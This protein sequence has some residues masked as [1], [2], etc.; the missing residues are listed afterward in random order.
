[1][2]FRSTKKV[3]CSP[4]T[5]EV[6]PIADTPDE[7]FAGKMMGDGYMVMPV[8]GVVYAPEDSNVT[9][10]FPT[11]HAIGLTTVDGVEYLLH[12]GVDTVKLEGKGFEMFVKDGDFVKKGDKLM[13]FDIQYIKEH[14]KSEA[15]IAVFTGLTEEEEVVMKRSGHVNA[16]EEIAEIVSC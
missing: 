10:V 4:F 3:L 11:N 15:C 1:M 16:Q 13:A 8:E 2:L 9:F 14:A 5:G 12:I 7:A 6:H